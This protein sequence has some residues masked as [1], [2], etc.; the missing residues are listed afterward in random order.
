VLVR[1]PN[2]LGVERTYPQLTFGVLKARP[3]TLPLRTKSRS[4]ALVGKRRRHALGRGFAAYDS[5]VG[6]AGAHRLAV[7]AALLSAAAVVASTAGLRGRAA[8]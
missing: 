4:P 1:E 6:R 8:R 5:A 3:P 7:M 2:Q